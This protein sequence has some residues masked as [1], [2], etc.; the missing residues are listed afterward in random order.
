[1]IEVKHFGEIFEGQLSD[2]ETFLDEKGYKY[3]MT[4][5]IDNI[6]VK[7]DFKFANI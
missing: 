2:L 3:Y 7:K 4:L 5:D 6:Y 1:L